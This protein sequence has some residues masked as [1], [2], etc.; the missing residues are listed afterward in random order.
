MISHLKLKTIRTLNE[1]VSIKVDQNDF[2]FIILKHK[3]F[4]AAFSLHG[5]HLV[6]F[7]AKQSAPLIY[8]SKTAIFDSKKAIR[9]G[10]PICWPW[11][12]STQQSKQN[13]LASHG[14]ARTSEWTLSTI[15]ITDIGINIEFSLESSQYTK[16]IWP[17]DFNLTLKAS[18]TD[19][20]E[21]TLITEN[22]GDSPFNYSGALHTYLHIADQRQCSVT[23]LATSYTDSLQN[24]QAKQ[25]HQALNIDHPIDS[26][27][28]VN[29][30]A[31]V[32]N[33]GA[34]QRTIAVSNEGNDSVVVWNP[35]VEGAK[36]FADMPDDGYQTMLCI[37]SAITAD[38]GQLVAAGETHSLKT[39]IK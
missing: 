1:H 32:V 5:A 13:G 6:H 19:H 22:T 2:E 31:I 26:I 35:W 11:F 23:G 21:L 7:Q 37:E 29:D 10:V 33:D 30:T 24:N 25:S 8:L 18:L 16:T 36:A 12:G 15:D 20:I 14:F 38:P 39:V 28:A 4:D 17:Y 34:Y 3:K 27:Y 9:G